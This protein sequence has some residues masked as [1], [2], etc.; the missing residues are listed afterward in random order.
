MQTS[1]KF[2]IVVANYNNAKYLPFLVQS[3]EKQVYKNWEL[4][5]VDDAST[6]NSCE[7]VQPYL[8]NQAIKLSKHPRNLG[9]AAAFKT[10]TELATGEIIGLLGADDGLPPEAVQKVVEFYKLNQDKNVSSVYTLAYDCDVNTMQVLQICTISRGKSTMPSALQEG[11]TANLNFQ[12]FLRAKYLETAGFD[13]QLKAAIDQD[14]LYKLEEVGE[15]L[16]LDKPLYYYRMNMQG[17]SRL[18]PFRTGINRKKAQMNAYL[19]RKKSNFPYN[20][21]YSTF[22]YHVRPYYRELSQEYHK[23]SRFKAILTHFLSLKYL[24]GDVKT[25]E[26]WLFLKSLLNHS[27]TNS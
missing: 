15:V 26:F 24:R 5:I 23:I 27:S 25:K 6:D 3:V 1:P 4:I 17:I 8:K 18:N 12:T 19:R 22:L 20:L 9:A 21:D 13:V 14:I 7:I 2:S 10:G 16:F 11:R